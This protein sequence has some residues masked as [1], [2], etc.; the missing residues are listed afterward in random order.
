MK[1]II[2]FLSELRDN[3]N[4]EWFNANKPR[5]TE[6]QRE[7]NTFT[8]KLIERVGEFEPNVRGVSVS[9]CTYRIYRD[10]RFSPDKTP[11]KTHIGAYICQGGKKSGYAGYYFH[12]EPSANIMAVGLHCPEPNVVKSIR[13]EI[14]T[15]GAA[16]VT[17]VNESGFAV[18]ESSKLKRPPKGYA[19][20]NEYIEYLKLKEFDLIK[21]FSLDTLDLLD[22]V[23]EEFR[24]C[25]PFNDIL[26]R[27]VS[28]A[29]E[30]P[31]AL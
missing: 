22:Y 1:K 9:D 28:F 16:L 29:F 27:A 26:N 5:Y 11:Y 15:N 30:N 8:E 18:D 6:V 3:N 23:T 13:E 7:F 12:V 24:R 10:T 17:A 20:D 19:A 25:K 14:F 31:N 21:S 4:R 2:D